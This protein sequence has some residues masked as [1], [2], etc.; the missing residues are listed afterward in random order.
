[1]TFIPSVQQQAIFDFATVSTGSAIVIAVAGSGKSTTMVRMLPL[2]PETASIHM[3]AF[4]TPIAAEL[5][6]KIEALGAETGRA[7]R[8]VRASTFH[9]IGYAAIIKKLGLPR[10]S[11]CP[12]GKKV[13]QLARNLLGDVDYEM[14]AS[15][16]C[17]LVGL[18]K[19]QGFGAI[20]AAD[21]GNWLDLIQHHDMFLDD[22]D[23]SEER[24][25]EIARQLLRASNEAAKRGSIDFDDQLYL[26]LLWCCRLWQNDVV[27][28]DE[29]Q[30]T[31]PV[32]RAIAKLTLKPGG[33]LFAV[34]DPRQAIYGFTGASHDALD[35]IRAEFNCYELPL[36]VSYRC[37]AAV[38][39]KARELVDYFQTAPG[40]AQGLV[41]ER[42]LKD[43]MPDLGPQ[44]AILCRNTAPLIDLAFSLIGKGV[45]C[46]I[47]GRDIASSL[48]GLIKRM[49]ARG[50]ENLCDKL[51]AYRDREVAKYTA[52]G[53]EAKAEAV[54][55]RV[56]CV[57][58]VVGHL[59]ENERTV[60]ALVAKIEGMFADGGA[61]LQL[62]TAHKVKG[63]E[64][65][66]V[67]ILRPDLMP[68]KWARQEWQYQQEMNICY[69][70]WT[71]PTNALF[72][73]TTE[74]L[75]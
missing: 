56:A 41:E 35:L 19:G 17:K 63:K 32:R 16:A 68:S 52:K 59:T 5:K 12:D 15:F 48:T 1:M 65:R 39:A 33:R 10:G 73:L 45:G 66:N 44:D 7:F 30:D 74:T 27:I 34:G 46:A 61:V 53:E 69:V 24:A 31:N 29:A 38:G 13:G 49:K 40:A 75:Q 72:F 9:S 4:N 64:F 37:P 67:G 58:A 8:G 11:V 3:F 50:V 25:V 26:P 20:I 51:A 60:P 18:A 22:E 6:L 21:E 2:F 62:A 28:I 14:Y 23:A 71:R 70:A 57:Q 54:A 42:T 55:D 36:T 43:A 47:M